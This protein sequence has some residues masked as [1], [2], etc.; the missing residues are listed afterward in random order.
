M[1]EVIGSLSREIEKLGGVTYGKFY[2]ESIKEPKDP[3]GFGMKGKDYQ[4]GWIY[5]TVQ[6]DEAKEPVRLRPY[7]TTALL[8]QRSFDEVR[9]LLAIPYWESFSLRKIARTPDSLMNMHSVYK[10]KKYKNG[11]LRL[12]PRLKFQK[13]LVNLNGPVPMQSV[14]D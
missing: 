6:F 12:V 2:L 11:D 7:Q 13:R 9:E 14:E 8:A 5:L 1:S 3:Y 4:E 10:L